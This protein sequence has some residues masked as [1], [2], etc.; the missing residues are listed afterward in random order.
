MSHAP[1][2]DAAAPCTVAELPM[3]QRWVS[4]ATATAVVADLFERNASL[5]G[6]MLGDERELLGVVLRSRLL[7][8]LSQPFALELYLK[9]PKTGAKKE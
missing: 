9:R 4:P 5:V 6:V 3:S 1:L 8:R 7:E 2:D